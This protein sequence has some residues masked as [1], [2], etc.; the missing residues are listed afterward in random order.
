MNKEYRGLNARQVEQ[1]RKAHGDNRLKSVKKRGFFIR[2][3]E[4][5]GDPIIKILLIALAINI[6][7]MCRSFNWF[8][9]VGIALAIFLATLVSTISEYGS[10]QA[11]SAMQKEAEKVCCRTVRDQKIILL[12]IEEL[13]VGDVV[14]LEAGE[15]VPADGHM[16]EGK[17]LM[18]QSALNG[19]SREAKKEPTSEKNDTW[20]LL[21]PDE[22]FRGSVVCSGEGVIQI[23]RV[24]G[25][26]FYG[27]MAKEL[28][29]DTRESPMRFRLNQLAKTV[30]RLGYI[31]AIIVA[32][33]YL[34]NVFVLDSHMQMNAILQKLTDTPFLFSQLLDALTLGITVIVVAVPEG[35]P[36]MITVVLSSNMKRMLKDKVLVRKLVGIETSGSLNILFTDKTGTLTQGKPSVQEIILADGATYSSIEKLKKQKE[37][38]KLFYW[39]AYYNTGSAVSDREVVGGNATDRAILSYF[40]RARAPHESVSVRDKIPFD[41]QRKFSAVHLEG[42]ESVYLIKGAP[43]KIMNACRYYQDEHGEKKIWTNQT[44]V[45]YAWQERT[46]KAARVVALARADGPI[47][48]EKD[49]PELSFIGLIVIEDSIRPEAPLAICDIQR[50]GIQTVMMTG[51]HKNTAVS[52]AQKCKLLSQ[53]YSENSVITSDDMAKVSDEKLKKMLPSLRVIARALPSDKS[54]L[55][56][57]AQENGL[58]VGMTGDGVNDAPALKKADVGFAMGSGTEVAK[59]ASDIVILDNNIASIEKAILYGRTIFKSIRKFIVFQ[60]MMNLCAV[61]ISVIGPFFGV[62]TPV[63]IIQMLWVNMI[64]DTLGGLAFAGEAP[65]ADYMKEKPKKRGEKILNGYMIYQIIATGIF[66]VA[67]C[68][69]FLLSPVSRHYFCYAE[70]SLYFMTAFFALF[71]F[72]GI[73]NCFNTRTHRLNLFS[74]LGRN[75]M[76]ILIM[77]FIFVVQ[78]VFIYLGGTLFRTTP[79]YKTDLFAVIGIAFL[80]IPAD[81]IRKLI[82][83]L[84]GKNEGV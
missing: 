79:L 15:R 84:M 6:I 34:F 26:T 30:S 51:D 42:Q 72:C 78:I 54:R 18:D 9:T 50:A 66:T 27:H 56:R 39:S 2:F 62:E 19:E 28:Q 10:E 31:A 32:F 64:M 74:H 25:D 82:G 1:S 44:A 20:D 80:V 13:V 61:G 60:L 21:F 4:N 71:I 36:M 11:F 70:N 52:V 12:P 41:S 5:F 37:M 7:F 77:S 17:L 63:T 58:V 24:G 83:R 47:L 23:G 81:L 49:F 46:K 8:E 65:L 48:K 14:L 59:E 69:S 68:L 76:F 43:E 73:F 40:M 38:Y 53:H 29:E 75:K 55:V 33:A 45:R 67:L 22:V 35:L 57:V 3:L 16:L